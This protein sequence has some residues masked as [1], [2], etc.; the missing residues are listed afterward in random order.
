MDLGQRIRLAVS[1]LVLVAL[2]I[3]F[4]AVFAAVAL[5]ALAVLLVLGLL[6]YIRLRLFAR[7]VRKA[8]TQQRAAQQAAAG[9]RPPAGGDVLDADFKVE[10]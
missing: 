5:V 10:K 1:V 8:L 2:G 3:L 4:F 7:R 9:S 6:F